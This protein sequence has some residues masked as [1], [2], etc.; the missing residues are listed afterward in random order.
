MIRV[1]IVGRGRL[2]RDALGEV[3]G[4]QA[5]IEV[6]GTMA[7]DDSRLP[8][9]LALGPDIVLVD[10][11]LPENAS[12][13]SLIIDNA[14]D[15]RVIVFGIP[16]TESAILLYAE[17][18]VHGYL[19]EA[20]TIEDLLAAMEQVQKGELS[21]PPKVAGLLLRRVSQLASEADRLSVDPS[22]LTRREME[23][24]QLIDQGLSNKDIA[25]RLGIEVSTA[26]NHVHNIL[27]KLHVTHR[28]EAAARVRARRPRW[29]PS[30]TRHPPSS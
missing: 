13:V 26:K 23:V 17:A 14:P 28:G 16:E 4:K 15:V 10:G 25:R 19:P 8:M 12:A 1:F 21:C 3:L 11:S 9:V 27:E 18:G 7:P 6:L 24:I 30:G 2:L 29:T 5:Q 20:G 22:R